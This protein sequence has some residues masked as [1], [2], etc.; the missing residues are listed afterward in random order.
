MVRPDESSCARKCGR[1][2]STGRPSLAHCLREAAAPA[3]PRSPTGA[4][5]AIL[6][7]VGL[8]ALVRR[9]VGGSN[10][11]VGVLV[12]RL[13]AW[14]LAPYVRWVWEL[15]D[16]GPATVDRMN[17][18]ADE[19]ECSRLQARAGSPGSRTVDSRGADRRHFLS[20]TKSTR[21]PIKN[22]STRGFDRAGA[23]SGSRIAQPPAPPAALGPAWR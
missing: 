8:G 19:L 2:G 13:S 16:P 14:V 20:T 23:R 15:I 10:P 17:R 18:R 5:L 7:V 22:R 3:V 9:D 1:L 21:T 11:C 12:L 6:L 4:L